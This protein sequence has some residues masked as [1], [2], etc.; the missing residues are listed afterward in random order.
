MIKASKKII[1]QHK[2]NVAIAAIVVIVL[3]IVG[4]VYYSR[5][6][7]PISTVIN[8]KQLNDDLSQHKYDIKL[9]KSKVSQEYYIAFN[10]VI[11]ELFFLEETNRD[12]L[13]SAVLAVNEAIQ[14]KKYDVLDPLLGQ[15]RQINGVE[16]DREVIIG[17]YLKDLSLDNDKLS[18]AK[19]KELTAN[20]IASAQKLNNAYISYSAMLDGLASKR[21]SWWSRADAKGIADNIASSN[22]ELQ[23]ATEKLLTFFWTIIKD[24][25]AASASSTTRTR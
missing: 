22:T 17:I 25:L 21:V 2:K 4:A 20:F 16:K 7:A 3:L 10:T 23:G 14:N 11:N 19:T 6:S 15:V 8:L 18:D 13:S 1:A 9:P 24:N 5:K 12:K